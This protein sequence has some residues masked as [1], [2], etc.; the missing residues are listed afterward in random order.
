MR[1]SLTS[2]FRCANVRLLE[3]QRLRESAE[4]DDVQRYGS[5]LALRYRQVCGEC[6]EDVVRDRFG[7]RVGNRS[8]NEAIARIAGGECVLASR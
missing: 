1:R 2:A 8:G 7:N 3:L 5:R 6:L 4:R